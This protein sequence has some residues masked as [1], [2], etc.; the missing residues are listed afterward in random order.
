MAFQLLSA[1]KTFQLAEIERLVC[2][3]EDQNLLTVTDQD[4]NTFLHLVTLLMDF[5]FLHFTEW[6]YTF[7]KGLSP[8]IFQVYS[9]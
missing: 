5:E 8:Q 3:G 1:I 7:D 2:E 9:S 4:G 6:T